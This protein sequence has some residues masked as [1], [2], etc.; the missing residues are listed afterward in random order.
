MKKCIVG[1]LL[2]STLTVMVIACSGGD[3]TEQNTVHMGEQN[4]LQSSV[5]IA[6]GSMLTLI[7]DTGTTHIILN[8]RWE[9]GSPRTIKEVGAPVVNLA[10]SGEDRQTIGPFTTSGVY[11]FYC[12]LHQGMNLT[13][14]VR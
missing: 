2:L 7:D 8:G 5:T 1:L 9:N 14:I 12:T 13:V 11:H 3:S 10:F 4:F 6:K